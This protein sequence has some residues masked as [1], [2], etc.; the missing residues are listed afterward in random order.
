MSEFNYSDL[1]PIGADK[2]K[3]RLISTEGLTTFEAEGDGVPEDWPA[4]S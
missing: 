4:S 3:Y 2:T 1:L